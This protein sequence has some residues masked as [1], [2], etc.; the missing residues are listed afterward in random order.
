MA[1]RIFENPC[2]PKSEQWEVQQEGA[3]SVYRHIFR[4]QANTMVVSTS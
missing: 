3:V 1:P 4:L 2:T